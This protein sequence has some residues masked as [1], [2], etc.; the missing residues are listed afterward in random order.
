M[1]K[2]ELLHVHGL[3][4]ELAGEFLE[5][6]SLAPEDLED[7]E[8]MGVTPTS[9]RAAKDDHEAAVLELAAAV[10]AAAEGDPPSVPA[11]G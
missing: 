10:A 6:G 11:G 1:K 5:E 3:L 4:A 7:Y 9:L 2:N 8:A